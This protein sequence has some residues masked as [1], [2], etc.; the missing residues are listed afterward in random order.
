M[1]N[2]KFRALLLLSLAELFAMAVWFS[3]SAVVPALAVAW[4]LSDASRAWL[5]M[6]VQI[7][8]VVGALT[9]SLLN[10]A[11][12][13]PA[14]R[15]L[16]VSAW[17]AALSTALIPS[18]SGV[19]P[20]LALRFFSGLFLAGVYPVGMKIIATWTKE[21]RGLGI[22]LLVGAITVGSASPHLLTALG[23][24][25]DWRSVLYFSAALAAVGGVIAAVFIGEGPFRFTT[26]LFNW[27]YVWELLRNREIVLANLGYLG[28]MWELYA[29]WVW[30]PIFVLAS[31][32]M[33]EVGQMWASLTGFALI[34]VGGIGSLAAGR[35]ADRFGRT[36]ITI[37]SLFISGACSLF[38]GFLFGGNPLWIVLVCLIW[39]FAVVADSAQFSACI[40]ELCRPEYTGTA[41]TLQT[42]LGFLLTL[43][44]IR[45]I[46]PIEHILGWEYA[47]AVLSLGPAIGIWAMGSLR[48]V[49]AALRLA[50]G[51]K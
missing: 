13:V 16:A 22:G 10:L 18:V 31:F 35:L 27:K 24:V 45:M 26:P 28:H 51:K 47:F 36:T 4:D 44:T 34:A 30:A 37:A 49:P 1:S 9:S 43:A 14:H 7:G 21:D 19:G 3:A 33:S 42:S 38:V 41:L 23:G 32:K 12:R 46:P 8:F 5:T 39:G 40:T 25:D 15:L 48:R 50:G 2:P 29:M 11:D 6:S 17:L 20:A